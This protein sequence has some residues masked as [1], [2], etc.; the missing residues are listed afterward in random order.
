[1]SDLHEHSFASKNRQIR[2]QQAEIERLTKELR[3]LQNWV[4][5]NTTYGPGHSD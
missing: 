3:D 4:M 5:A 1:M 2:E